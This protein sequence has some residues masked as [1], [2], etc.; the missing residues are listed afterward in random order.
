MWSLWTKLKMADGRAFLWVIVGEN[1]QKMMLS[2]VFSENGGR[3]CGLGDGGGSGY[4]TTR[5]IWARLPFI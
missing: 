3:L 5:A 1:L 4:A 2:P